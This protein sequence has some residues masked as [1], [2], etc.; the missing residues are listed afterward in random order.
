ME[1][2]P[3][4]VS[5][6]TSRTVPS[7]VRVLRRPVIWVM[8]Y[9]ALIA[10]GLFAF[11]NIPVEVLPRFN[12]PQISIVT[13]WPG[14]STQELETL[15]A[16]PIENE[17]LAL[18]QVTSIRSTIGHGLVQTNVRFAEHSNPMLDLQMVNGAIDRARSQ[19]PPMT[20]P[21][22]EIMGNAINEVADYSL[23][24]PAHA[25]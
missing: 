2:T 19:L 24:L 4:S 1:P 13:S 14:S 10:Y 18:T 7:W 16:R 23:V 17:L 9:G 11:L 15:I 12:F 20:H 8:V 6:D 21:F 3:S 5:T 22:A 25:A